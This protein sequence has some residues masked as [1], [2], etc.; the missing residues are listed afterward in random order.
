MNTKTRFA[1][2]VFA[3][4][5]CGQAFG[6]LVT[7]EFGGLV[8]TDSLDPLTELPVLGIVEGTTTFTGSLTFDD[9]VADAASNTGLG[10]YN[11]S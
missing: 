10:L 8:L 4:L 9:T 3:V 5:N 2:L 7:W 11:F 1:V 6:G